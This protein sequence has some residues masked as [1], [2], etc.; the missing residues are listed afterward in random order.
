MDLDFDDP[1]GGLDDLGDMGDD[2]MLGGS[3]GGV[4]GGWGSGDA[5]LVGLG[6]G[7]YGV[8]WGGVGG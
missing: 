8:G 6:A 3:G 1:L 5:C 4:G 7:A 2:Y